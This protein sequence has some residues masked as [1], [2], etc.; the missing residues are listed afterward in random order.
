MDLEW[1]ACWDM[2]RPCPLPMA[3]NFLGQ[4]G[5]Y[6]LR[7]MSLILQSTPRQMPRVGHA[8]LPLPSSGVYVVTSCRTVRAPGMRHFPPTTPHANNGDHTK[9]SCGA[10]K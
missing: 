3:K 4:T 9:P 7:P 1:P 10:S 8:R 6:P 5:P 2:Q